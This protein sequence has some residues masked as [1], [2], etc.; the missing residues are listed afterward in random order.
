[1]K[2]MKYPMRLKKDIPLFDYIV[3][4]NF[5]CD[6]YLF[7]DFDSAL[8]KTMSLS[9][10]TGIGLLYELYFNTQTR[11][12]HVQNTFTAYDGIV[13]YN[14]HNRPDLHI[15]FYVNAGEWLNPNEEWLSILKSRSA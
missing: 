8:K 10:E 7:K 12:F 9:I 1:V 11:E 3:R 6:Y 14:K 5:T 4:D 13:E 15:Q 2:D